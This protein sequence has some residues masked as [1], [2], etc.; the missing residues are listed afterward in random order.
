MAQ[1]TQQN[2]TSLTTINDWHGYLSGRANKLEVWCSATGLDARTMIRVALRELSGS[3]KKS[4]ALRKCTPASFFLALTN[5]AH[6][7][8]EPS[9][10]VLGEAYLIP[11]GNVCTLMPGYQGLIK[12]VRQ[13]EQIEAIWADVVF[14]G[15]RFEVYRGS[16]PRLV[17]EPRITEED[18]GELVAA[19]ACAMFKGSGFVQFDALSKA[20]IEKARKVSRSADLGPWVDWYDEMSKKTAARRLTKYLP[21]S[22][23]LRKALECDDAA[24]RGVAIDV[25]GTEVAVVEEAQAQDVEQTKTEQLKEQLGGRQ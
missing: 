9:G 25:T 13:S 4:A 14:S 10:G 1:Q 18:R 2:P 19:Y 22:A 24:A 6:L 3:D 7:G 8:L 20:E 21:K 5:A 23:K 15:D 11:F 12:L 17:H 16:Q